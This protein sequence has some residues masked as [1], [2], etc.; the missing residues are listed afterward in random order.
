M[1][2]LDEIFKQNTSALGKG[3]APTYDL[4]TPLGRSL[5]GMT[6]S[7]GNAG[8]MDKGISAFLGP[9]YQPVSESATN[10]TG[11]DRQMFANKDY[12]AQKY[13]SN[14]GRSL[15]YNNQKDYEAM[16]AGP[17]IGW[18]VVNGYGDTVI[19][20]PVQQQN[21][22]EA[23][24]RYRAGLEDYLKD[25]SKI[26]GLSSGWDGSKGNARSAASTLYRQNGNV[27]T[28]IGTPEGFTAR[29][30]GNWFQENPEFL[31][32]LSVMLPAFGGWAGLA[33][34]M[35]GTAS[36]GAGTTGLGALGSAAANTAGAAALGGATGGTRGALMGLGGGVGGYL[37]GMAG[38]AVGDLGKVGS[39]IGSTAGKTL[40]GMYSPAPTPINPGT[41]MTPNLPAVGNWVQ[42]GQNQ[43]TDTAFSNNIMNRF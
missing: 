35:A 1:S 3:G 36:M 23:T 5:L 26:T 4:N 6:L 15:G 20:D 14:L 28:P 24:D 19:N 12:S 21:Q 32:A 8:R 37:G 29:E 13:M 17:K 25:I 42:S 33:G 9:L 30:K 27:L 39:Q 41:L 11:M 38:N 10:G 31:S 22:Y 43:F 16:T 2:Y 34:Q 40:A 7:A 18:D